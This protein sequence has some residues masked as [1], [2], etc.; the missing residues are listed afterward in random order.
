MDSYNDFHF[1]WTEE[2]N[3]YFSAKP[4]RPGQHPGGVTPQQVG[5]RGGAVVNGPVSRL[6]STA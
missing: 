1:V 4:I 5:I 2:Y 6:E 3:V